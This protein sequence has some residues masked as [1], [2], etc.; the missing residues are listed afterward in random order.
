MTAKPGYLFRLHFPYFALLR[1]SYDMYIRLVV[2][3]I[4]IGR[5][6]RSHKEIGLVKELGLGIFCYERVE[7]NYRMSPSSQDCESLL[8]SRQDPAL[9]MDKHRGE[10]LPYCRGKR[11]T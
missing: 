6:Q 9:S 11:N 8:E 5:I 2:L 1:L 3:P 7:H 10:V 4:A